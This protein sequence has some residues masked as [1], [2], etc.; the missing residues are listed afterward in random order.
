MK[1]DEKQL[2]E[3]AEKF[4]DDWPVPS[5]VAVDELASLLTRLTSDA[6]RAGLVR[7]MEIARKPENNLGNSY[8]TISLILES[9]LKE[10]QGEGK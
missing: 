2:Q 1:P 5:S 4:T 8:D 3:E 6:Y 9:I 10:V 7:A